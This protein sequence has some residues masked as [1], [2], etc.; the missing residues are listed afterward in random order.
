MHTEKTFPYR[1]KVLPLVGGAA[2]LG[3]FAFYCLWCAQNNHRGLII[4]H[5]I[6]LSPQSATYFFWA[7][8]LVCLAMSGVVFLV[9]FFAL[10]REQNVIL[11]PTALVALKN[12]IT[13]AYV[14][15]PYGDIQSI[16]IMTMNKHRFVAITH[17]KGKLNIIESML[18]SKLAFEEI[19]R[20]LVE[21][22]R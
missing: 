5:I 7:L 17:R 21:R 22:A 13:M 3:S 2:L 11:G 19:C 18:P 16:K 10:T 20:L 14:Q 6:T 12:V 9:V 1:V 15:V 4:N 8:F